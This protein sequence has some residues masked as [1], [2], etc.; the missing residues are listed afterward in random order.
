M[1]QGGSI[2]RAAL[3]AFIKAYEVGARAIA[4]D[5]ESKTEVFRHAARHYEALWVTEHPTNGYWAFSLDSDPAFGWAKR[6]I[7]IQ[8]GKWHIGQ[9][10][11]GVRELPPDALPIIQV[12]HRHA[13][14]T[15]RVAEEA[16]AS[17]AKEEVPMVYE[18]SEAQAVHYEATGTP[19]EWVASEP[20]RQAQEQWA[21]EVAKAEAAAPHKQHKPLKW[22]RTAHGYKAKGSRGDYQIKKQKPNRRAGVL[23]W[24]VEPSGRSFDSVEQAKAFAYAMDMIL[25]D[26]MLC[27]P[28]HH[29]HGP[30]P[31]VPTPPRFAPQVPLAP[32]PPRIASSTAYL[33]GYF[34][35]PNGKGE[36]KNVGIYSSPA[37][38]QLRGA[39]HQHVITQQR[40]PSNDYGDAVR[41]LLLQMQASGSLRKY[42]HWPA[43]QHAMREH[44]VAPDIGTWT[45]SGESKAADSHHHHA[46]KDFDTPPEYVTKIETVWRRSPYEIIHHTYSSNA[47][48]FLSP[49]DKSDGALFIAANRRVLKVFSIAPRSYKQTLEEAIHW[50][51]HYRP[52][53]GVRRGRSPKGAAAGRAASQQSLYWKKHGMTE[54]EILQ[55][56]LEY[57]GVMPEDKIPEAMRERLIEAWRR[58]DDPL[59]WKPLVHSGV[60]EPKKKAWVVAHYYW[61]NPLH[62]NEIASFNTEEE[63]LRFAKRKNRQLDRNF[64]VVYV[65]TRNDYDRRQKA[66]WD[67][68]DRWAAEKGAAAPQTDFATWIEAAGYSG[69]PQELLPKDLIEAWYQNQDPK[70][71]ISRVKKTSRGYLLGEKKAVEA[72]EAML[73]PEGNPA[74]LIPW[75]RLTRDTEQ[76]DKAIK[77]AAKIGP[78]SDCHKVYEL[79]H[80]HLGREDQEVF[81]IVACDVKDHLRGVFEI[82]RGQ[83]S[84]VSIGIE[85][86]VRVVTAS[87]ADGFYAVHS[88]PSGDSS[89]SKADGELTD[90]IADA[91]KELDITFGDHVVVGRGNFSSFTDQCTYNAD[92]SVRK[93]FNRDK[94]AAE[95]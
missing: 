18:P 13:G 9:P 21:Q 58:G 63:A 70:K 30:L 28:R 76:Y 31:P 89:P 66:Y 85:D 57:A 94:L 83:R 60:H 47:N 91:F 61:N 62:E 11:G 75:L 48:I 37:V 22:H 42:A 95:E 34:T 36:L 14:E 88:H 23:P 49:E 32:P 2:P 35:K 29:P 12:P 82:A 10:V 92:G 71:F 74:E 4:H 78:I 84:Q 38:T 65:E 86:I 77:A 20:Q 69:V 25:G 41:G 50:A 55:V 43:V 68:P 19:G 1:T 59:H 67:S 90:S 17:A 44:G 81:I 80:E 54:P 79:L 24:C 5:F 52:N 53:E 72:N 39:G 51:E 64:E 40:V 93:K 8:E 3:E 73:P 45:G 56:W 15:S 26:P 16:S 6:H 87:G 7:F 33:V 27:P 46:Q